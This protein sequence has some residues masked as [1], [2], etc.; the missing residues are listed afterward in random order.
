M[1]EDKLKLAKIFGITAGCIGVLFSLFAL[2]S[3]SLVSNYDD[4][5]TEEQK[6][7]SFIIAYSLVEITITGLLSAIVVR[8]AP[9]WFGLAQII[10]GVAGF[11]VCVYSATNR[12]ELVFLGFFWIPWGIPFIIGGVIA[13]INRNQDKRWSGFR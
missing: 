7:L 10:L 13:I 11:I 9:L 8:K 12:D 6:K 2:V 1:S 4:A 5:G 3:V